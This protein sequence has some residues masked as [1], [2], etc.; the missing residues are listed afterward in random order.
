MHISD[1]R[2]ATRLG[3]GFGVLVLLIAIVGGVAQYR[4]AAINGLFGEVVRERIPRMGLANEIKGDLSLIAES[5]RNIIMMSSSADMGQERARI[6]QARA[7]IEQARGRIEQRLAALRTQSDD[8]AGQALMERLLQTRAV[9][10]PLEAETTTLALDGQVFEAKAMLLDKVRPAQRAYF[11]ALDAVLKHQNELLEASTEA[12]QSAATS[13]AAVIGVLLTVGLAAGVAMA[14]WIIRSTTRPLVR[15]VA[16]ARAV[17]RG[18][19]HVDI[20]PRGHNEVAQ[21]LEALQD[22]QASL[23]EVVQRVRKGADSV[24]S[25]SAEIAQGNLDLS[26]R[27]EGQASALQQTAA[28]MDELNAN[29]QHN[30]SHAAQAQ[31]LAHGA[32]AVA[33]QGGEAVGDVVRTMR[34][35][36]ASS[37]KIAEI[38]QVIDG[39]AFQTNILA[40]NAAVEAARAGEQGRGFAVVAGEVR[41]LAGRSAQA[42]KEIKQLI[43]ESV[44]RVEQGNALVDRAGATMQQVV[45]SI[46]QVN[47]IMTEISAASRDQAG[48]V[49]QVGSSVSQMDQA[50]QQNAALVE[51]MAASA[52]ALKAQSQELVQ[53]VAVFKL[54]DTSIPSARSVPASPRML[55]M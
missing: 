20:E 16:R 5:V 22:M 29:V 33:A 12:T 18:D 46:G 9:Y 25:A 51:E 6:E 13:M 40:L 44:E 41:A 23:V 15:A 52:A 19:L 35:I 39:I 48:A 54:D 45:E 2:I 49:A 53:A 1:L 47:R 30:A 32:A 27:T 26:A 8:A 50:T 7:R 4:V 17:A 3:L 34:D 55:S 24:S 43:G 36:H 11:E 42:A 38:I 21:L 31:T 37:R 10:D 14:L 28:R